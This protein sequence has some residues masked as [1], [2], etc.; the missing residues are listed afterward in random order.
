MEDKM[1]SVPQTICSDC[2]YLDECEGRKYY[3]P[4]YEKLKEILEGLMKKP[5]ER[6]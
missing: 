2:I 3:C 5:S 6:R 4:A 1:K